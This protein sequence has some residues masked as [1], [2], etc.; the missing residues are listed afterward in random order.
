MLSCTIPYYTVL[1]YTIL[2]YAILYCTYYTIGSTTL[3][4]KEDAA[5]KSS[6]YDKRGYVRGYI[7]EDSA[8]P[9]VFPVSLVVHV[10]FSSFPNR[11]PNCSARFP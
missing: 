7:E 2:Y 5:R 8:S 6:R 11:E 3:A 4:R 9:S 10:A 1:Y